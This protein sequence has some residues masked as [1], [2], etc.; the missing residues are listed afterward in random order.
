MLIYSRRPFANRSRR[1]LAGFW[2]DMMN[3]PT[4]YLDDAGYDAVD[5]SI[6]DRWD[7][8]VANPDATTLD[9][10]FQTASSDDSGWSFNDIL[11]TGTAVAREYLRYQQT[12]LPGGGRI[13]TTRD[14]YTGQIITG[15]RTLTLPGGGF[16][17]TIQQNMPLISA[18]AIGVLVLAMAKRSK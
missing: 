1:Q 2:D 3:T 4:V 14:P 11:S 12:Q 8:V 15:G 16:M 7:A 5:T 9:D 6:L 17:S 13:Y 18:G 10:V